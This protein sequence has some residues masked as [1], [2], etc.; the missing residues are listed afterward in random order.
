MV[1][2]FDARYIRCQLQTPTGEN[3]IDPTSEN[4][5][6]ECDSPLMIPEQTEYV[7]REAGYMDGLTWRMDAA[8]TSSGPHQIGC[9][10]RTPTGE[11]VIDPTSKKSTAV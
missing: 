3:V 6:M 1:P 5:T 11:N 10:L 4:R 2:S 8:K 7:T 9:Y